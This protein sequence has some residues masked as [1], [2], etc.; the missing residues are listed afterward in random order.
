MTEYKHVFPLSF[1]PSELLYDEEE[2]KEILKFFFQNDH[3]FIDGLVINDRLKSFAQGILIEAVDAS[4][5]IGFVKIIYDTFFLKPP[6][7][8]I[9]KILSKLSR[10]AAMHWFKHVKATDLTTIKIYDCVR[11][12]IAIKFRQHFLNI[13]NDLVLNKPAVAVIAYSL[14]KFNR[15]VWG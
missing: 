10:K 8:K 7:P 4:Y 15:I 5:E 13:A 3:E 12:T 14:D 9:R 1:K 11:K 6:Q 2:T